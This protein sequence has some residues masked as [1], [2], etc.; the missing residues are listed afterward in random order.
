[1]DDGQRYLTIEEAADRLGRSAPTVWRL[2]RQYRLQTYRRPL[3]RK[4]FV[5]EADIDEL[6]RMTM[7]REAP[8]ARGSQAAS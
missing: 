8:A 2:I 4:S 7:P 5:R 1:M 6:L 3:N